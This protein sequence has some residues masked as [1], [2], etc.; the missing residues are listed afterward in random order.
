M[1]CVM[2]E[3]WLRPSTASPSEHRNVFVWSTGHACVPTGTCDRDSWHDETMSNSSEGMAAFPNHSKTVEDRI[4]LDVIAPGTSI[5]S[6]RWRAAGRGSAIGAPPMQRL[7]DSANNVK[8]AICDNI[9]P[10]DAQIV[11][12]PLYPDQQSAISIRMAYVSL[13]CSVRF[14]SVVV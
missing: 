12:R 4:K 1:T 10:G 7:K 11:V 2:L 14:H 8:Q 9:P 6:A 5:L 3:P 13:A